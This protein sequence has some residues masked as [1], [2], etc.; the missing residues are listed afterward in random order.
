MKTIN[1]NGMM[2]GLE[3]LML[4]LPY[5]GIIF[6]DSQ[7]II[8]YANS[9]FKQYTHL[10]DDDLINTHLSTHNLDKGLLETISTGKP[11]LLSYYPQAKLIASRQPMFYEGKVVGACGRYV[12]L[13][14][15]P[16]KRKFWDKED[17]LQIMS[18]IRIRDIMLQTSKIIAEL[19]SYREDFERSNIAVSGIDNIIGDSQRYL[20]DRV[21]RIA[22]S[23]SVV[24]ITGESGVGKELY[25]Q[26]IHF[27]SD[28]AKYP[29]VKINCAAIPDNLLESELFG[30]VDGAFTGA[31]KG[32]KMGKFELADKGTIFLDEIGDM[33][34]AMQA[35]LLRVLQEKEIEKIGATKPVQ[36]N[37]RIISATNADLEALVSTGRFRHDLYYRLNVVNLHIP[38]LRERR[39]DIVPIAEKII[40]DLNA[41][42][43][44]NIYGLS[45][46]AKEILTGHDWPGNVRELINVLETAMNFCQNPVIVPDDL[47]C[48][49]KKQQPLPEYKTA[50]HNAE[51]ELIMQTLLASGNNRL[52]NASRLGISRQPYS[53]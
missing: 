24:L 10:S 14:M 13:D 36:V 22:N 6:I 48:I 34:L 12:S 5:E 45:P 53:D 3:E 51:R 28:R 25:A 30:Y 46:E 44:Q 15:Y 17:F 18:K 8:R 9:A 16:I 4:D 20:K 26:A 40:Q 23:P 50:M 42:L 43:C 21:L 35:K 11:D 27:H 29:F 1:I 31:R 52:K 7:G 38:P 49:R 39:Q 32:G 47:P 19:N 37:V 41:K 33:P 2:M